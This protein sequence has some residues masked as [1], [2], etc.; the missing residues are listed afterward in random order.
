MH[1]EPTYDWFALVIFAPVF[2]FIHNHNQ[3]I[4]MVNQLDNLSIAVWLAVVIISY[5]LESWYRD[6]NLEL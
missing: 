1:R 3:V 2:I 6:Q 4:S 5:Y